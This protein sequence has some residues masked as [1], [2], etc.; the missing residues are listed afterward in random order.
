MALNIDINL[1]YF[2]LGIFIT[3]F[4]IYIR[5]PEPQIYELEKEKFENKCF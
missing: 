5:L 1:Q 4:F 3:W 2:L